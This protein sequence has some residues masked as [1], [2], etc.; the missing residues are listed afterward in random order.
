MTMTATMIGVELRGRQREQHA[1][2]DLLLEVRA[3]RS[4]ALVLRGEAGTGK[5]AL[6]DYLAERSAT[7]RVLRAAGV[8][9]E[10]EI[11]YSG[12]QQLCAPLLGSLDRL[13]EPQRTALRIAFGLTVGPAPELLVLGMATLGL[14]AEAATA[15]PVIC[16]IDDVQW[17]DRLSG[18]ILAFAARRLDAESVALVFAARER[19]HETTFGD[20]LDGLPELRVDGLPEADARAL[21]DSVLTGPVDARV[22]DRIVAETRGNPLAL[23]ELTRGLSPEEL[24]FGFGGLSVTPLASRVEDG[25][26]RRIA[27]LAPD[28]RTVL[29][30]AAIEPVGDAL[31]L[32]RALQLLGVGPEAAMQAEAD[33]LIELGTRVRFPHPLVRSAAWRSGTAADLRRVHQALAEVTDPVQDPDRRA[34]HRA[35]AALGPDEEVAGELVRSAGRAL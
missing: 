28:A 10:S 1:L 18:L 7:V 4:R 26:R 16:L 29:L 19:T 21:L 22:R 27:G 32:W 34:W 6:L 35:H 33:G 15:E 17:L 14:F 11:A 12:L 3:G 13:P 9:S 25:F 2:D 31:L 20:A 24:A 23:L 30:A 8:E 5:T